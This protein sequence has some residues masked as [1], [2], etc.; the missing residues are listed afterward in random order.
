[1]SRSTSRF[2]PLVFLAA[3]VLPRPAAPQPQPI[4][5][6]HVYQAGA[7][8]S[9][10]LAGIRFTIP[11]GY[12]GEWDVDVGAVILESPTPVMG[13]VW[14]W[15]EG[16]VDEV[17]TEVG[18]RLTAI[19]VDLEAREP[20]RATADGLRAVFVALTEEGQGLLVAAVRRGPS[21]NVVAIAAMGAS[22][23]ESQLTAFVDGVSQSV[24]WLTPGG[25][26]WRAEV[27]GTVLSWTGGSSDMSTGGG[28]TATGAS[29][30]NASLALCAYSQ[31]RYTESS[32][33]YFSIEGLSAS[34]SSSD[35]HSGQWF[36][37]SDLA[38]TPT[39]FLDST[40]GRSLRWSVEEA[41]DGYL[42]DGSLYHASGAC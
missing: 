31:Y 33:S 18:E 28:A 5:P 29:Q 24:Q 11:A 13:G 8:L 26:A 15:S 1:M 27:E 6:G 9:S 12:V 7:Q 14:G 10:P 23:I 25:A 34:N 40:D 22:A 19:G 37:V 39:L 17:A 21:G 20:P 41:Q 30:S 32:E 2:A 4:A 35:E 38:G 42:I 36:L 16:T 3:F